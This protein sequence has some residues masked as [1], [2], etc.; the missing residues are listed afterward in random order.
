[1]LLRATDA[2][3]QHSAGKDSN[4]KTALFYAENGLEVLLECD[5]IVHLH[6]SPTIA[7]LTELNTWKLH[8]D[9]IVRHQH[10]CYRHYN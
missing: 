8:V 9:P 3:A 4:G 5:G 10:Q 7:V 2:L 6:L 1:M